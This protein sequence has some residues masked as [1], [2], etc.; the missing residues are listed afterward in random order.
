MALTPA[1]AMG[2]LDCKGYTYILAED[3]ERLE[4]LKVQQK[5]SSDPELYEISGIPVGD[6][7]APTDYAIALATISGGVVRVPKRANK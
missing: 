7:T 4:G 1:K 2:D 5:E 3:I 6:F